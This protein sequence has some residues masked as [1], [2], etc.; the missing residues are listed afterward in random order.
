[1]YQYYYDD[2]PESQAEWLQWSPAKGLSDG[3]LADLKFQAVA[4]ERIWCNCQL[5]T[6]HEVGWI[7]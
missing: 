7:N 2:R 3:E 5:A 1:M 6:Q 4:K